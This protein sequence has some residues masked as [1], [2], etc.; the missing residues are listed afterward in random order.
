MSPASTRLPEFANYTVE[1]EI[2]RGGMGVV[3]LGNHKG[4][5]RQVAI[6]VILEQHA[7]DEAVRERFL[8]EARM[9]ATMDHPNIVKVHDLIERE[10]D[11][12][13][14]MEYVDG[15]SLEQMIGREVGPIPHERALPLF[16]QLLDAVGYAHEQGIIHR[17]LKPANVL[18]TKDNRIKVTDFGIAKA[19]GA[20]KLTRTGTVL[21]TP[22]YMAP[23]QILGKAVDHRADIYA[24]G[25]TLYVM[26]AG[27]APFDEDETSEFVLLKSCMEDEI[28]D[29]RTFYPYIPDHLIHA[30]NKAL[31]R[32]IKL[33]YNKCI[34]IIYAIYQTQKNDNIIM[35]EEYNVSILNKNDINNENKDNE[36]ITT[37]YGSIENKSDVKHG[38]SE[39]YDVVLEKSSSGESFTSLVLAIAIVVSIIAMF[40]VPVFFLSLW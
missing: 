18:V 13:F 2:G 37:S 11:V 1:R 17:D 4:L 16:R 5:H 34:D 26:L 7:R 23:E 36:Y 3:Y 22:I 6:K 24:L 21:G 32:S 27:R 20:S 38:L 14:V 31:E 8:R 30:I 10:D 25:M 29:P 15:R 39:E 35:N 12:A 40:A 28:P 19:A 9:M 33:R